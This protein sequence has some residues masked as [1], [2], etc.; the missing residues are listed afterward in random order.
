MSFP[1]NATSA[2]QVGSYDGVELTDLGDFA[3]WQDRFMTKAKLVG[4]APYYTTKDYG[5]KPT[6]YIPLTDDWKEQTR[7][8]IIKENPFDQSLVVSPDQRLAN[9][10]PRKEQ[11]DTLMADAIEI[12]RK[13]VIVER[14]L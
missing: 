13:Q 12:F 4:A 6:E 11:I 1:V 7:A 10:D 5:G 3:S 14:A 2:L 9:A 8:R